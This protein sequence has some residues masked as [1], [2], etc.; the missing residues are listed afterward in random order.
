MTGGDPDQG[1]EK[2]RRGPSFCE[3]LLL[4]GA[5]SRQAGV[6]KALNQLLSTPE[7]SRRLQRKG[8]GG[9]GERGIAEK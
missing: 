9:R 6:N 8:V 7:H 1:R 3:E 2:A 4:P 5:G